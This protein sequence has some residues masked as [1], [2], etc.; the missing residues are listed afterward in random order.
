MGRRA[1]S[2]LWRTDDALVA[3]CWTSERLH[4]R[5]GDTHEAHAA[6]YRSFPQVATK[7]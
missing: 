4:V 6:K 5:T 2:N 7:R 3:N 1:V